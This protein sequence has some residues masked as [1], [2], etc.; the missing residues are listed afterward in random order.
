MNAAVLALIVLVMFALGYRFYAGFLAKRIFALSDDEP[1]P[2]AQFEDGVDYL[3]TKS[4]TCC[5]VTT[6]PRS[7]GRR[8]LLAPRSP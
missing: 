1:M 2:A 5:G 3:P 6:S 7:P 4:C 8:R